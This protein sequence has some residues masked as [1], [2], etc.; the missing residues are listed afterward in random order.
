MTSPQPNIRPTPADFGL[1]AQ[2]P[3]VFDHSFTG[4]YLECEQMAY[5]QT[6]LGRRGKIK[7]WALVWGSV[8][9]KIAQMWQDNP[10]VETID[11]IQEVIELNIP[12]DVEDRYGRVR[13]RMQELFLAWVEFRRQQPVEILRTEQP[14]VIECR[15]GEPCPYFDDGC[16]LTYG[17][18]LDQIVRWNQLVG[19][20]DFKTTIMTESDPLKE[21]KPSH[22][23]MGY[24]WQTT[25]LMG[26][27]C[28]GAIVER[29]ICN[30][31]KIAISR[32]PV[33]FATDLIREWAE[34]EVVV[35][36]EI[37]EKFRL[38]GNNPAA[39]KTNYARCAKPYLCA[40]R[41]ICTSP[42]DAGFRWRWVRDNTIEH[43]FD[44]RVDEVEE[45]SD[46]E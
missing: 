24:T 4:T 26:K 16:G 13:Y 40:F 46:A 32:H 10:A 11:K 2:L 42:R 3:E 15:K 18:R 43:R 38:H 33:S 14:V 21:Y 34:R 30:K 5:L 17:G 6:I 29:L 12:E 22:Q 45:G 27:E 20:L 23:M 41:D 35:H 39:W 7:G 25:H 9:H 37:R 44:F 28:W 36:A 31:S 19:P 1:K 8:F